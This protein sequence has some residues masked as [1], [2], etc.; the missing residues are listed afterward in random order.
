M[1]KIGKD[2]GLGGKTQLGTPIGWSIPG[3]VYIDPAAFTR[4]HI[5]VWNSKRHTI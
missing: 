5:G 2:E 1:T 3:R 4:I